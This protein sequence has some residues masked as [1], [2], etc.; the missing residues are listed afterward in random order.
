MELIFKLTLRFHPALHR[1]VQC[2]H[3]GPFQC[4]EKK[5]EA[6]KPESAMQREMDATS[7]CWLQRWKEILSQECRR[8]LESAKR[9][10]NAFSPRTSRKEHSPADIFISA[11]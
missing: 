6:E 10:E 8:S 2:H 3:K 11:H 1:W 5:K 7:H 9:Q 4:E